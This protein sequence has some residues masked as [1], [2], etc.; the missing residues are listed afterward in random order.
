MW[1]GVAGEKEGWAGGCGAGGRAAGRGNHAHRE[2]DGRP[3]PTRRCALAP[4]PCPPPPCGS[5]DRKRS[6]R[7][8]AWPH[9]PH[10][11]PLDL[12]HDDLTAL[13]PQSARCL[14][15]PRRRA[16]SS[17]PTTHPVPRWPS[18]AAARAVEGAPA[19]VII[20]NVHRANVAAGRSEP[21]GA[22]FRDRLRASDGLAPPRASPAAASLA[23]SSHFHRGG[24][25]VLHQP[26]APS[27]RGPPPHNTLCLPCPTAPAGRCRPGGRTCAAAWRQT[28]TAFCVLA[29]PGRRGTRSTPR[30]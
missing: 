23:T 18:P 17:I 1:G 11:V 29:W 4:R 2:E 16:L 5:K 25:G 6:R 22:P 24:G 9:R 7:T 19:A 3:L 28:D 8:R 15:A 30:R 20:S 12:L 13:C 26:Q 10:E 21:R 27:R 14:P